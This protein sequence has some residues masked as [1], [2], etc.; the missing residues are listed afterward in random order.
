M[1]SALEAYLRSSKCIEVVDG[2]CADV[3]ATEG[4]DEADRVL[5]HP[6]TW[7]SAPALGLLVHHLHLRSEQRR[8]VR[9]RRQPSNST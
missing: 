1:G 2:A 9:L 4:V 7:C 6:L 8:G 5:L 3:T